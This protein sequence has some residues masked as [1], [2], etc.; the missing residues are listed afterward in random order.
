[1]KVYYFI[2]IFFC[3]VRIIGQDENMPDAGS[4]HLQQKI[5]KRSIQEPNVIN[6]QKRTEWI[7][8]RALMMKMNQDNNAESFI[9][10]TFI[11]MP[12]YSVIDFRIQEGS[13]VICSNKEVIRFS[14][15]SSHEDAEIGDVSVG[16]DM[17]DNLYV[18]YGHVCGGMVHFESF[19]SKHPESA[20]AFFT[21]FVSNTDDEKWHKIKL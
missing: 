3:S 13:K 8:S 17:D 6:Q 11:Q 21:T 18:N 20:E 15:H 4:P 19:S 1:M 7:I 10:P 2:I 9:K 12:D 16:M 5:E 14:V